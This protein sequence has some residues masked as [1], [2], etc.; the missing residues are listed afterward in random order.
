MKHQ[1]AREA[2]QLKFEIS[3]QLDRSIKLNQ[4]EFDILPTIWETLVDAIQATRSA[5]IR[6]NQFADLSQME[7][8]RATEYLSRTGLPEHHQAEILRAPTSQRN[9]LLSKAIDVNKGADARTKFATADSALTRGAIF[10]P[11]D[12]HTKLRDLLDLTW[13]AIIDSEMNLESRSG[14][15]DPDAEKLR[16]EGPAM[17]DELQSAIRQRLMVAN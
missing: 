14:R 17:L 7:D 2:E 16:I 15:D 12:L 11:E 4:R 13:R 6:F 9:N 3:R 8:N 5:Y 1:Y 10:L